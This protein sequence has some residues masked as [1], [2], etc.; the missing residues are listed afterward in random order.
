MQLGLAQEWAAIPIPY[1]L[2]KEQRGKNKDGTWRYP[3]GL[4]K[5]Q[6]YYESNIN[7]VPNANK[8]VDFLNYLLSYMNIG[9]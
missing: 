8:G 1:D 2:T 9:E 7:K 4:K 5:G 6:S 3:K